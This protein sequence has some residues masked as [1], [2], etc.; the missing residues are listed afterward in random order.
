MESLISHPE[1]PQQKS[2]GS[3]GLRKA[4]MSSG[5]Y[6][7]HGVI[8]ALGVNKCP[9]YIVDTMPRMQIIS[10]VTAA[11]KQSPLA[12]PF[13]LSQHWPSLQPSSLAGELKINTKCAKGA[14]RTVF[15]AITANSNSTLQYL[16]SNS[17]IQS[18]NTFA[19]VTPG[20]FLDPISPVHL[21]CSFLSASSNT[22]I[23]S[24]FKVISHVLISSV[25]Q[26]WFPRGQE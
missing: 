9:L 3:T 2:L 24:I 22:L 8:K 26:T 19:N 18:K 15:R 16:P 1:M 17:K 5:A 13:A 23:G 11:E 14:L 20:D 4:L 10:L 25:S 7:T 6:K 21:I 12:G